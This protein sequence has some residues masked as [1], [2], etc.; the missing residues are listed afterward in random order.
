MMQNRKRNFARRWAAVFIILVMFANTVFPAF[1]LTENGEIIHIKTAEDLKELAKNCRLDTWSKGKTVVLDNDLTFDKTAEKFLPIPTFGGTLN[2]NGYSISGLYIDGNN[3][4]V[5]LF[6][7]LQVGAVVDNL[8]VSGKVTSDGGSTVG[9]F[10]GKNYGKITN[11]TFKGT[12]S[13]DASVGGVAG[14]NEV[15][16]QL[17]NCNFQGT[18]TGEHY[19]GGIVGHNT[20]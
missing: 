8:T 16:G 2:G 17:I 15:S 9:G 4:E 7:T 18:V 13:G 3:S 19:V 12:V 10:V 14:I 1:S 5:G 20:M 11:C 6:D